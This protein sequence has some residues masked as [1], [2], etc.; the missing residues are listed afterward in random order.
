ML[1]ARRCRSEDVVGL[2]QQVLR[3]HQR[4]EDVRFARDDDPGT[5]HFCAEDD[6]GHVICV[7]TM[8][9]ETP[10]WC[11]GA[12]AAW[13]LRGMATAPEWQGRGAGSA[14]LASV[15][16]H[17]AGA[18]GGLLWCNARMAAVPFYERVGLV[19]TGHPWE[20]PVIGPHVAM[21][22][23]VDKAPGEDQV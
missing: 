9:R 2:R 20:E 19:R 10:P 18:G 6:E 15:L 21:C 12:G 8:W 5:A 23:P 13:R 14:V 3:P 22:K 11:P 1:A 4:L 17:V 7:A 16:S